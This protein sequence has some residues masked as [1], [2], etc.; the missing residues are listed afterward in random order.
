MDLDAL[1]EFFETGIPFNRVLGLKIDH[2]EAG[3][4]VIKLPFRDGLIGDSSRPAIHGGVVSAT[5]DTA[6]GLAL[7]SSLG[8]QDRVS[9]ID[10]RVDY[11][12]HGI[13][14]D[15]WC[16]AEVARVGNRV[17]TTSM[18][19]FQENDRVIAECRAVYN[20]RRTVAQ[21]TD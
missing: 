9:T 8:S 4:C 12:R 7:W 14:Q 1:R 10:M 2:L 21:E 11:L 17:G 19:V 3:I 5:A 20:I 15:L 18:V 13:A 16:R 6:G